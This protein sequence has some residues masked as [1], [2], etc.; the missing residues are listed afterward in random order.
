M[1]SHG[2]ISAPLV[3]SNLIKEGCEN[4]SALL[5]LLLIYIYIY[6]YI[7]LDD[8]NLKWGKYHYEINVFLKYTLDTIIGTPKNDYE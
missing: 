2:Q 4:E 3:W 5:I 6:I 8:K 1:Y 7:S